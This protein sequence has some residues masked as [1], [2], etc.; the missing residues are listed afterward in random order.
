MLKKTISD[1]FFL[2]VRPVGVSPPLFHADVLHH[3]GSCRQG[4][5]PAGQLVEPG[6]YRRGEMEVETVE[7]KDQDHDDECPAGAEV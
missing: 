6:R 3:E 7:D 2:L 5:H 4:H 1:I